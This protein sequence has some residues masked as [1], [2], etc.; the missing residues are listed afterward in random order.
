MK[1]TASSVEVSV[2][3]PCLNEEKTIGLCVR[4]ALNA[5]LEMGVFGE[6]V[7]VD[8]GSEDASASA[9][10]EMG[11]RVIHHEKKG[12]GSALRRGIQEARGRFVIMGD[13]DDTY[14]FSKVG[15]FIEELHRGADLVMGNRLGGKIH[16]HA[17]PWHHRWLGTPVL[18]WLMNFFFNSRIFDVNCGLRGFRKSSIEKLQLKS[19]GMEFASEM[20]M[21]AALKKM[22]IRE[23]PINYYPS[24]VKRTP[25][26]RSFRDGWRHLRFMLLF[27][28]KYLFLAPGLLLFLFGLAATLL[29]HFKTLIIFGMPLGI[30]SAALASALLFVGLQIAFFGVFSILLNTSRGF[31]EE[32]FLSGIFKRHFTLERGLLAGGAV[33]LTG[34]GL[35][36]GTLLRIFYVA[37]NLPYTDVSLAR[38]AIFSIFIILL[39]F[40]MM[41]SSFYISAFNL[42]ETLR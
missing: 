29:L 20:I 7:V 33:S 35:L 27:C 16:P 13:G 40:Q 38:L 28:P 3:I 11:A 15:E 12:Y 30:S 2:I 23:I 36:A 34:A 31:L 9:A 10:Q 19:S 5:M 17:M 8:N 4:K 22:D 42:S 37:H 25:H 14:D 24:P 18:T 1:H 32:G 41:F 39:G 21:K 26:L 6:V